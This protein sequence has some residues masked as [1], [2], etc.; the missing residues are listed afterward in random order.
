[1][2]KTRN[3]IDSNNNGK[4]QVWYVED[5]GKNGSPDNID[6]VLTCI[7]QNGVDKCVKDIGKAAGWSK[8]WWEGPAKGVPVPPPSPSGTPF[9]RTRSAKQSTRLAS[10][11]LSERRVRCAQLQIQSYHFWEWKKKNFDAKMLAAC[12][13]SWF[14]NQARLRG[15][16][17]ILI[18]QR[19]R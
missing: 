8:L 16:A 17:A 11:T 2:K 3:Y 14:V 13:P 18:P 12:R 1:M 7:K 15:T 6:K 19:P 4:T 9:R 10:A 5:V